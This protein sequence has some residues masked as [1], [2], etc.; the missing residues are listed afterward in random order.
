MLSK[1]EA[2]ELA[3][4]MRERDALRHGQEGAEPIETQIAQIRAMLV[5]AF[6][7][8]DVAAAL[9]LGSVEVQDD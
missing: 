6:G 4:L 8:E 1:S 9:A 2:V 5:E 7:E 3:R